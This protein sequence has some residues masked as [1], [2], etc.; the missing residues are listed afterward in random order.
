M[1]VLARLDLTV[2]EIDRLTPQL[3][4]IVGYFERLAEVDVTSE[5]DAG[6]SPSGMPL[7]E[8][9]SIS[10]EDPGLSRLCADFRR[11]HVAVPR[12]V[13]REGPRG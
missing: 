5:G 4:R 10:A 12:V 1:A 3:D 9:V 2:E 7:R 11:G 8:D 6:A 13:T